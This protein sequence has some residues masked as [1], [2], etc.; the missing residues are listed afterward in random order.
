MKKL[1]L[2]FIQWIH[3]LYVGNTSLQCSHIFNHIDINDPTTMEEA[4]INLY[5][6]RVKCNRCNMETWMKSEIYVSHLRKTHRLLN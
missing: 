2:K 5:C 1:W 3:Q 4:I 6:Y